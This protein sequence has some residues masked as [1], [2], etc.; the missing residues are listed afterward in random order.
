LDLLPGRACGLRV[1]QALFCT[2]VAKAP[3]LAHIMMLPAKTA[4]GFTLGGLGVS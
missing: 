4:Q 3:D 2:L 1:P